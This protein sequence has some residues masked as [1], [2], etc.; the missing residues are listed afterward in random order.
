MAQ[1]S[2]R[3][4]ESEENPSGAGPSR[5]ADGD[6]LGNEADINARRRQEDLRRFEEASIS[7]INER[8]TE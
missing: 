5:S 8:L 4:Q 1:S 7:E 3:S 6:D 2:G